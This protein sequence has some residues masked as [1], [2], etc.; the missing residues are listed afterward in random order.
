MNNTVT[1]S[2]THTHT[3]T[4]TLTHR[5]VSANG[6]AGEMATKAHLQER[7]G[8]VGL[9]GGGGEGQTLNA[10]IETVG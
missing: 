8:E 5:V 2:H 6:L 9:E 3:H 7:P 4:H 1:Q 10:G